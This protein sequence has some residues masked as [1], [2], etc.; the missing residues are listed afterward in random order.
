MKIS[1]N[2]ARTL[3]NK[4]DVDLRQTPLKEF[5]KGITH[6]HEHSDVI[7][8]SHEKIARLVVAHL[9]EHPRYYKYLDML[10]K[11]L[12]ESKNHRQD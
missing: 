5:A 2:E 9:R 10:E 4:L 7:G 3:A 11:I 8:H 6:E 1:L 12:K